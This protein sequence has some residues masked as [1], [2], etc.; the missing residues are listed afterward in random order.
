MDRRIR[1]GERTRWL[2]PL[3]SRLTSRLDIVIRHLRAI[4]HNAMYV[5]VERHL[6]IGFYLSSSHSIS[7]CR[8]Y[9]S[10]KHIVARQ[11][12]SCTTYQSN[13]LAY[14]YHVPPLHGHKHRYCVYLLDCRAGVL[15]VIASKMILFS[16]IMVRL[17]TYRCVRPGLI[18]S[19]CVYPRLQCIAIRHLS[20]GINTLRE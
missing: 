3:R 16:E 13:L 17:C 10:R 19:V 4:R 11:T 8:H 12:C 1:P 20:C 14:V 2:A 18:R 6:Y 5:P 15:R 7:T 9:Q